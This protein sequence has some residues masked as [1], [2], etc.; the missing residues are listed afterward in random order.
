MGKLRRYKRQRASDHNG[1]IRAWRTKAFERVRKEF[2][3]FV[4]E[5]RLIKAGGDGGGGINGAQ[6]PV[7]DPHG[8]ADGVV[9]VDN[10]Q[11][12]NG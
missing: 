6:A 2:K 5:Q 7:A 1:Y 10:N 9:V 3:K 12:V 4:A 8:D 11:P